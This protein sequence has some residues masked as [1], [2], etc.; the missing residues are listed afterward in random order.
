[1][2]IRHKH[3]IIS[4]ECSTKGA[5]AILEILALTNLP[6]IQDGAEVSS[7]LSNS[8]R[9]PP[10]SQASWSVK[11]IIKINSTLCSVQLELLDQKHLIIRLLIHLFWW[12]N[13]EIVP[14][15]LLEPISSVTAFSNPRLLLTSEKFLSMNAAC[16]SCTCMQT[17]HAFFF[18]HHSVI[19]EKVQKEKCMHA[20]RLGLVE[21]SS[22]TRSRKMIKILMH[23]SSF[24]VQRW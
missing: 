4:F 20:F 3:L 7:C 15:C 14:P 6:S 18:F 12:S 1:M 2:I 10:V 23:W 5:F 16:F 13:A 17:L 24:H 11:H 19:R 8:Y 22:E 9:N 21:I